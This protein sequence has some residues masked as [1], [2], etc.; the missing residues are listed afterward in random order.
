[1][2]TVLSP[3]NRTGRPASFARYA[4]VADYD[5]DILYDEESD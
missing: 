5:W 3:G 4:N 1:M 2:L